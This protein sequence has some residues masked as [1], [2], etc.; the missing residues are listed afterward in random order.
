[1]DRSPHK[2]GPLHINSSV[3]KTRL[4]VLCHEHVFQADAHH[5]NTQF[6]ARYF[7]YLCSDRVKII[8][9]PEHLL[10][11]LKL[12][13]HFARKL[14]I[15]VQSLDWSPRQSVYHGHR[16]V[17]IVKLAEPLGDVDIQFVRSYTFFFFED[18]NGNVVVDDVCST[19]MQ[20]HVWAQLLSLRLRL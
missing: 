14:I 1:M 8:S 16:C 3:F 17:V 20:R 7:R 18:L 4:V 13:L 11:F 15:E 19:N 2:E 12:L 9:K 10:E 6:V 5:R